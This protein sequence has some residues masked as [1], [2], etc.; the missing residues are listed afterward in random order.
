MASIEI[1]EERPA[2][3]AGVREVNARAFGQGLEGRI[4]D[5]LRSNRAMLLSLVATEGTRIVGHIFYSPASVGDIIGAALGPMSVLPEF[6]RQGI[7]TVLVGAGNQILADAG[8][9]FII[10]LGHANSY[11]RFG[12][13]PA[14]T[15]GTTCEWEVPSEVFMVRVLDEAKMRGV[16]GQ[17]RYRQEFSTVSAD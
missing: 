5:A 1:R 13:V 8:I 12:F 15:R 9:P 3:E 17:A 7:G 10:V 6:Q 4:V 16:S 2:D 11:P 14:G